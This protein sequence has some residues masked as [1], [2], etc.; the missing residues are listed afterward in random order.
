M[1]LATSVESDRNCVFMS[2]LTAR[3]DKFNDKGTKVNEVL[4]CKCNLMSN[5]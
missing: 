4:Q 2:G 1:S 3:S 5:N